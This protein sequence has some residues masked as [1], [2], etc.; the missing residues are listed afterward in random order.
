MKT[1]ERHGRATAQKRVPHHSSTISAWRID[2][3]RPANSRRNSRGIIEKVNMELLKRTIPLSSPDITDHERKAVLAVL[4]TRHLSLGPKVPEF[5][6]MLADYVG[7]QHA[8]AINSGTSGLHLCVK[9]LGITE[10]DEVITTPFSFVASANCLLYERAVPVFVDIDP[11]TLNLNVGQIEAKITKKTRAILPVHV[12]G[13]PCDMDGVLQVAEQYNLRVIED[14][15]E[16]I[17]AIDKGKKVGTLGD[18]GVFAFYPNKQMTTGEGGALVTNHDE[19]AALCRSLRNQ[20]RTDGDEWL[21]HDRLGYNYRLSDIHCALGIA[22]IERIGE[23]LSKRER[24]A[25]L[26][27]RLLREVEGISLPCQVAGT[28]RSWFVYVVLLDEPFGRAQR[29]RLLQGLRNRGIG[30]SNYFPPIH[31]Q[32]F[33]ASTFGYRKGDFSVTESASDRT[34][35]LPFHGNLNEEE[36]CYVVDGLRQE[37]DKVRDAEYLKIRY[38]R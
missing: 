27:N 26:Y 30:C 11:V 7:V 4:N 6:K 25:G 37:L 5:E 15:C 1:L 14:A 29:D 31:L 36:V 19:I 35:A 23:L 2:R 20:G 18:C 8:V 32:P 38:D 17:G 13:Q 9:A 21:A 34:V 28:T 22:Q 24:V 16:A 12:F 3:I 10:G 33:Y